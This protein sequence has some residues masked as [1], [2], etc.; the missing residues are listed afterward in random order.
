MR[1][2]TNQY[3]PP[4]SPNS[5]RRPEDLH[6]YL[7]LS[8][9]ARTPLLTLWTASF[10][11]TCRTIA[12]LVRDVVAAGTGEAEG[13]VGLVAIEYDAPDIMA[14]GFGMQYMI[15]ALPTLLSF[16]AGEPQTA[17][18][19]TDARQM[20]DR[21]WLEEWVRTEARRR[22]NRGGGGGGGSMFGGLFSSLK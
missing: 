1:P 6:T 15:T 7:Q 9:T 18:R 5:V 17:T 14:A 16:D 8:A 11:G 22:G 13:G 19:V 10:C 2:P 4:S 20:A 3:P 12:P 21:Q